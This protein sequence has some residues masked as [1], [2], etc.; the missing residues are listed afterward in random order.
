MKGKAFVKLNIWI[1]HHG[2]REATTMIKHEK[3]TFEFTVKCQM[4][5]SPSADSCTMRE[6]MFGL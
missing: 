2:C 1:N 3:Q 6:L 5:F 4:Q